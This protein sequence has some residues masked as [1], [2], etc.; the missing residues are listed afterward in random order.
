[1]RKM[2]GLLLVIALLICPLAHAEAPMTAIPQL[3]SSTARIPITNALYQL[4][5]EKYGLQGPEPMASKTHGAWLN[6]ADRSVD[7]LFTVAPMEDEYQAFKDAGI[8]LEMKIYGY[9]GLVFIGNNWNQIENMPA[10]KL[11]AIYAGEIVDWAQVDEQGWGEIDAYIRNKESGSQRLFEQLVWDGYDM[12]DFANMNFREGNIEEIAAGS[13]LEYDGMAGIVMNV[14]DNPYA[15]GFNI[16]SYVDEQ[17]LN[18]AREAKRAILTTGDVNMRDLPALSGKAIGALAMGSVLPY[19]DEKSTDER[20]V[21]WYKAMHERYGEVWVS[22]KY[23]ELQAVDEEPIAIKLFAVDGY[24][25]T[26]E[27]FASGDYPYVTTS[28]IAIRKDEPADS[29]ARQLFNWIGSGESLEIIKAN[30]TL[31][32]KVSEPFTYDGSI[33]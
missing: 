26:T 14:A 20:G 28:I 11:R 10:D 16:M 2:M 29:P 5:T 9:D 3:D 15:I 19:L 23:A 17:F 25:P 8:E 7:F 24:L 1:M 4:F 30:S 21:D 31:S 13:Y 12:P 6:L 33:G 32:V 18:P 27:N 22:S